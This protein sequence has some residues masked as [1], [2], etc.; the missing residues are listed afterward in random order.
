[1]FFVGKEKT[2]LNKQ[3]INISHLALILLQNTWYQDDVAR[4]RMCKCRGFVWF[5]MMS[6]TSYRSLGKLGQSRWWVNYRPFLLGPFAS[7][8]L[9]RT[10]EEFVRHLPWYHVPQRRRYDDVCKSHFR[11][12][13]QSLF[14]FLDDT[15]PNLLEKRNHGEKP[16]DVFMFSWRLVFSGW[17]PLKPKTSVGGPRFFCWFSPSCCVRDGLGSDGFHQFQVRVLV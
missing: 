5:R 15:L 6:S 1:M 2:N 7:H 16:H 17:T 11:S 3:I 13:D 14:F 10:C 8:C 12:W 9:F 4:Y